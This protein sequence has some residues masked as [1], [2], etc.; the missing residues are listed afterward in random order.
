M[1]EIKFRAWDGENML[2]IDH[3]TLSMICEWSKYL[4]IQLEEDGNSHLVI[5]STVAQ[6]TTIN[7]KKRTKKYPEGQEIYGSIEINNK[8]SEGGDTI[9]FLLAFETSQTHTGDNIPGGSYTEPDEPFFH[10]ITAKV[11]WDDDRAEWG[12]SIVGKIPY[13]FEQMPMWYNSDIALP[14]LKREPYCI[15]YIKS[16]CG[17][18]NEEDC[19]DCDFLKG[20][21]VSKFEDI[22]QVLNDI[23][24]ISNQDNPAPEAIA[25]SK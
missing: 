7:D 14:I 16:L 5:P 25:D 13:G 24:V 19:S 17:E 10:K 23:E 6:Y 22:E 2:N 8:M 15:E 18:C 9:S 21:G 11:I 12:W 1:K 20:V 3:W 4:A